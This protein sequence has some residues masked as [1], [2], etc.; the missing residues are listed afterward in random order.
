[1]ALS[2]WDGWCV[3]KGMERCWG[4]HLGGCGCLTLCGW[5]GPLQTLGPAGHFQ[6][7]PCSWKSELLK[8]HVNDWA[9]GTFGHLLVAPGS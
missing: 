6:S 8:S 7:F 1:M 3:S 9:V 5:Q 4:T 2:I